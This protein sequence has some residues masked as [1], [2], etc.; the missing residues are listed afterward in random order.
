[1]DKYLINTKNKKSFECVYVSKQ[2]SKV[3]FYHG[4]DLKNSTKESFIAVGL[5]H[6]LANGDLDCDDIVFFKDKPD[7]LYKVTTRTQSGF[8]KLVFY[9]NAPKKVE[10][11]KKP[12]R[13]KIVIETDGF[14]DTIATLYLGGTDISY[15]LATRS[16][17]DVFNLE[18]GAKLALERLFDN[19][20]K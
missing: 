19:I 3:R 5:K 17:E 2:V 11:Y 18:T 20:K 1:M 14:K 13:F 6:T 8:V 15:G 9:K 7:K 12:T 4:G 10:E 16:D